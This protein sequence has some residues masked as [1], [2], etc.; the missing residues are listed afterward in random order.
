EGDRMEAGDPVREDARRHAGVLARPLSATRA[1]RDM[2]S[3]RVLVTGAGGFV[4]SHLVP[5]LAAH[6]DRVVALGDHPVGDAVRPHLE[7]ERAVDLRAADAT[8]AAVAVAAPDAVIHLAA[9][10]SAARSFQD[11]SGTFESNVL[12]TWNLLLAV[13][14][15]APHSRVVWIGTGEVYGPQEPGTRVAED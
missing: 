8:R 3:R 14:E 12:G 2:G 13:R 7:R 4:A 6:G 5:L 10:S 1:P 9:Q 11:P 15:A